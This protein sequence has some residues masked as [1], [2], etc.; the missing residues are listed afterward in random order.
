MASI[1]SLKDNTAFAKKNNANFPILADPGKEMS[2]SY[3]VLAAL[4]YAK[5]WTFY[6][7]IQG[8]IRMIDKDV[9]P[10][11]AGENMTQN[12]E[13]LGFPRRSSE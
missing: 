7:D 11:T 5:R 8:I 1:D 3:G 12:L 13:E 10:A 6:I 2:R 4:G 9:N